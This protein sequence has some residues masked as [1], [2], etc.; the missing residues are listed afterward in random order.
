MKFRIIATYRKVAGLVHQ[1]DWLWTHIVSPCERVRW[2]IILRYVIEIVLP[3]LEIAHKEC[4]SA[5]LE[6]VHTEFSGFKGIQQAERIIH[7]Y[8][9]FTEMIAVIHR[10]QFRITSLLTDAV[11]FGKFLNTAVEIRLQL[12]LRHSA[13]VRVFQVH[14]NVREIV[15]TAEYTHLAELRH[16]GEKGKADEPVLVL[17]DAVE[18]LKFTAKAIHQVLIVNV[19]NHRL[20]ILV[21]END[22]LLTGHSISGFDDCGKTRRRLLKHLE[23]AELTLPRQQMLVKLAGKIRNRCIAASRQI[24]MKYRRCRPILFQFFNRKPLEKLL[25]SLKI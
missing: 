2:N 11:F 19:V 10:F 21:Y 17:D 25:P 23:D 18:T 15:Q 4:R 20:V 5:R 6:P 14:R 3:L 12:V 7:T 24:Q 9:V 1:G 8:S 16:A 22:D 13:D